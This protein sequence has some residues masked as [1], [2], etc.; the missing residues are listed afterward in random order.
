MPSLGEYKTVQARIL[1]YAE[2]IGWTYVPRGEAARLHYALL[3][4]AGFLQFFSAEFD[5][6]AH[7]VTLTPKPSFPGRRV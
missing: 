6:E 5:G 2:E 1:A 4:Q 7:I 3:G